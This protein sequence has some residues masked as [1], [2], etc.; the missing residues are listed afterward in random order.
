M[1]LKPM[2]IL[3]TGG[4]GFVGSHLVEELLRLGVEHVVTTFLTDEPRG[5]FA[6]SGLTARV[7]Q[8]RA[9]VS[10]AETVFDLVTRHRI[11]LI[12]H[13]AAQPIVEVAFDDPA[14]TFESNIMGTVAILEA[15]RR[16]DMVRGVV[17]ASSDKAYGK[18]PDGK[19]LEDHPLRG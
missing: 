19:Y 9:D 8:V 12:F 2:N 3:V 18:I 1:K 4:T 11:Q 6:R 16:L 17:V 15:A 14:R 13:L 10:R 5:Y 7:T